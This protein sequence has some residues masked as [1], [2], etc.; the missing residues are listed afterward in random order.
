MNDFRILVNNDKKYFIQTNDNGIININ[1]EEKAASI[2]KLG[3]HSVLLKLNEKLYHAVYTKLQNGNY[4]IH[5]EGLIYNSTVK[6]KLQDE[7][8]ELTAQKSKSV[9]R[10][11]FKAPMPGLILKIIKKSGDKVTVGA[12]LLILEAM[13]MENEMK[14]TIS[15]TIS[16]V[17]FKEGD[18]VEKGSTIL[19]IE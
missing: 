1:G 14:S 5:I 18:S 17:Y 4:T 7:L 16:N 9:K 2:T 3:E 19:T 13:K 8:A 6:T 15:G 12:P 11:E 10:V